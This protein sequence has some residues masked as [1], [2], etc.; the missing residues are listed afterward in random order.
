MLEQIDA[1][2]ASEAGFKVDIRALT[3]ILL[4]QSSAAEEARSKKEHGRRHHRPRHHKFFLISGK[5]KPSQIP[6]RP[7]CSVAK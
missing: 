5:R 4:K 1:E 2:L 6:F 3:T 7:F